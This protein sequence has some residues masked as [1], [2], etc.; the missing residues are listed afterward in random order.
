MARRFS[1]RL[2]ISGREL[3]TRLA[4]GAAALLAFASADAQQVVAQQFGATAVNGNGNALYNLTVTPNSAPNTGA[5]LSGTQVL[6]TDRSAHGNFFAVT[7]V[8]N[9]VTSAL[10]LVVADASR[11]QI[12][13][14]PGPGP[15][16]YQTSTAIFS[17]TAPGS[18][19]KYP[20]GLAADTAGNVYAISAA[21]LFDSKPS[22]W[23]LPFN[24]TTGAY[25]APILVD[26]TCGI[27]SEVLVAA[28]AATPVGSSAPAWNAGD[29]LVLVSNPLG[30]RVLVY[31]QAALQSVLANPSTPLKGPTS[32]AVSSSVLQGTLPVGMD[33][34]PADATHG[35]SLLITTIAGR[36]LRFDSGS[37]ALAADFA[38]GL[39]VGLQRIKVGTYS[40]IPYAFVAQSGAGTGKILQ[41]GAPPSSGTNGPLASVTTGVNNPLGLAVTS[42]GSAPVS[43][44]IAPAVCDPLG[45]Q[46]TAQISG[47]GTTNLPPNAPVLQESCVI[48]AD[49][50]VTVSPP[51]PATPTSWS[52]AGGNLDV[53]NFC[54]GFPSTVLP[55]SLCG[56]SGPTGSGFVVVKGTA[57]V[58]DQNVNDTFIQE[59]VDPDVPLPGPLN[60][61]CPQEQIFAWAPRSDLPSIEGTI[62]EGGPAS[63]SNYFIDLSG[64]CDRGGGTVHSLSMQAYGLALNTASTG[65]PNGL[66]AFVTDKFANLQQTITNASGQINPSNVETTLLGYVSQALS[67]FNSGVA[68]TASNGFSCAM[69][70]LAS[71]DNYLRA[72]LSAFS[73]LPGSQGNINPAG[74]ISGRIANVFLTID[75]YFLSEPPN[76][77]WPTNNVPPCES[78]SVTPATVV[79]SSTAAGSATLAWSP[80]SATHPLSFTAAQCTLSASD[81][82]FT[83]PASESGSGS[84]STGTLTTLGTYSAQIICSAAAGNTIT[85]FTQA[86]ANVIALV[87]LSVMP[88]AP[89]IVAGGTVQL[90][91]K[92]TYTDGSN[93]DLTS[94]ATWSSSAMSVATVSGGLVSCNPNATGQGTATITA[95]SATATGTTSNYASVTC[96]APV[97]QSI[98]VTPSAPPPT[99]AAGGTVQL[100]ATGTYSSGPGQN[101]SSSAT[102]SSSAPSVATVSATGLVTCNAGASSAGAATITAT[103]GATSGSTTVNCQA[104]APKYVTVTPAYPH[105]VPYGGTLQLTATAT[106]A[107]GQMQ[108]VTSTATWSSNTPSVATVSATGLVTCQKFKSKYDESTKISATFGNKTGYTTVTCEEP[109]GGYW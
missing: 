79:V 86:T 70:S 38:S 7:R 61:S 10:D 60:L 102:W 39:G 76:T 54:P 63:D 5:L 40:T 74:E 25:G 64:L 11:G 47:P 58:V 30:P 69:N 37:K 87:S 100:T 53:A 105:D 95:T 34:W 68:G 97:L 94:S 8:S 78:L 67:Y 36:V 48:N 96:L 26:N 49:P 31:S 56:H 98:A 85:S 71:G 3:V 92:G 23:V 27:V 12:V 41:F 6:N 93:Q 59:I 106:Y 108:N 32:I 101:L 65:L 84:V 15:S 57:K 4:A 75:E 43:A 82:T 103:S 22:L 109:P 1:A 45:P 55:G 90:T 80:V 28:T 17:W 46:L 107:S 16:S 42:S 89:N 18:G 13:R 66:P 50:R 20:I 91:A 81:G 35:V 9:S 51:P 62:V 52:C 88:S 99:V 29:V 44:C 14:Y 21:V 33:V 19:P 72:N 24:S 83:T 77:E 104:A 2:S 73:S